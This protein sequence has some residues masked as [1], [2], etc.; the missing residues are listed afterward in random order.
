MRGFNMHIHFS[1]QTEDAH[2]G[3]SEK[4]IMES[5]LAALA[6]RSSAAVERWTHPRSDET[7]ENRSRIYK[8]EVIFWQEKTSSL[9]HLCTYDLIWL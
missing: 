1:S 2:Y 3:S 6:T 7:R 9:S 8:L 4:I 5:S